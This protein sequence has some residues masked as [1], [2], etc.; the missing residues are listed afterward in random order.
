MYLSSARTS[1]LGQ[2]DPCCFFF[3]TAPIKPAARA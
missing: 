3:Q 1:Q 2:T